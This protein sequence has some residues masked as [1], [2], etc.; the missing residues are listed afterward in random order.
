MVIGNRGGEDAFT[1]DTL[2]IGFDV[3]A[4]ARVYGEASGPGNRERVDRLFRHEYVHLLQK[5]WLGLHPYRDTTA[6]GAAIAEIWAEGLG[7][8]YS[9]SE[10]WRMREGTHSPPAAA[11]LAR[12]EP[13]LVE[14][15]AALGCASAQEARTLTAE[16]S[17]APFERK[18]GALPAA[19]W[20]E[21]DAARSPSALREFVVEG[22]DAVWR[23][24]DR[25]LPPRLGAALREARASSC[26]TPAR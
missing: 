20:L 19:L 3:S 1:H 24:A 22:P 10:R 23:L 14:R 21:A 25:S 26:A 5:R 11:A 6:R 16:L 13:V 15:L 2:T 17:F 7:V 9:M 18:W 12:L 4:L 8:W